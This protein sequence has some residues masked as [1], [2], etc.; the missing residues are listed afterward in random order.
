MFQHYWVIFRPSCARSIQRSIHR[1]STRGPEDDSV[2]SKYIAPLSHYM[3][4]FN[5]VVFDGTSPPPPL[6]VCRLFKTFS[7]FLKGQIHYFIRKGLYWTASEPKASN[8]CTCRLF[9]NGLFLSVP[10]EIPRFERFYYQRSAQ[11]V[12]WQQSTS[13]YNG[14][15]LFQLQ[16]SYANYFL[17]WCS[18][19]LSDR[20]ITLQHV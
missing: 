16:V 10:T 1:S 7:V 8:I 2:E 4:N 9:L 5:T 20:L 11:R 17:P 13:F 15:E 19:L 6:V 3:F 12:M 18:V 14:Q